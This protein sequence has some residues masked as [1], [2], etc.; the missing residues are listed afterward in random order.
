MSHTYNRGVTSSVSMRGSVFHLEIS[1]S[2]SYPK[3]MPVLILRFH[4]LFFILTM[5]CA[6]TSRCMASY[7]YTSRQ[8]I[9]WLCE[10]LIL[11]ATKSSFYD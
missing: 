9:I 7:K 11:S 6:L 10:L 5:P 4:T 1:D 3:C 8:E 2:V